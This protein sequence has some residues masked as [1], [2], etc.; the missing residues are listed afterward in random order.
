[1]EGYIARVADEISDI[2]VREGLDSV[3]SSTGHDRSGSDLL[4]AER[5]R[6][7]DVVGAFAADRLTTHDPFIPSADA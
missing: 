5:T 6:H 4:G 3:A 2:L 1:M 7:G